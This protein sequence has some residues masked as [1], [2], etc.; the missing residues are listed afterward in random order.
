MKHLVE[1]LTL[2]EGGT[3]LTYSFELTDPEFLV[4]PVS[5]RVQWSHRPDLDFEPQECDLETARRFI[6]E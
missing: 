4:A 1:R 6:E 3:S 5:G 2:D